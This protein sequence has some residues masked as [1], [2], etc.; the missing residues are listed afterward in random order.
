VVEVRRDVKDLALEQRRTELH[1]WLSPPEP[2]TNYNKALQQRQEGTGSWFL[3]SEAFAAWK[4]QRNSFLW[5]Y[6]IPGCGKTILSST[7]I[8][9]LKSLRIQPLLYFYFDF[10]DTEK[11]TL[12]GVVCSLI[13]QLYHTCKSA[14]EPLD[15]LFSSVKDKNTQASCESLCEVLQKMI[16]RAEEVWIVLDAIDECVERK[17]GPTKGLL[18]WMRDLVKWER[19]NVRCLVTSRPEQDIRAE[20]NGLVSE[21]NR[22]SMQSNLVS[23]DILEYIY[24]KVREGEGMKRWRGYQ[25]VQQEIEEALA[26][27]ADG[28]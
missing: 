7:I 12:R 5:L 28:M 14:Q 1:R 22:I 6:G 18:L 8:E 13:S 11:Q 9:H 20:L 21:E 23:N 3:Q 17:G 4:S 26:K 19:R 16:E 25:D 10:T 27:K 15:S 2:S 24:T